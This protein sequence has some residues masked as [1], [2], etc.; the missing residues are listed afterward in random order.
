MIL[1]GELDA[2]PEQASYL[3]GGIEEAE[4]KAKSL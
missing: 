3:V 2:L 4:T 1:D